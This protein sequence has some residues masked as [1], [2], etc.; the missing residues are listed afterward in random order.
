[1]FVHVLLS[2]EAM[3]ADRQSVV[4]GEDDDCVVASSGF[5]QL[6]QD[7]SDLRV[8][9]VDHGVVGGKLIAD[10]V[11]SA[12]QWQQSIRNSYHCGVLVGQP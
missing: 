4:A 7:T 12:W 5:V 3:A 9:V 11:F 1:M 10:V 6:L 2:Q 8:H